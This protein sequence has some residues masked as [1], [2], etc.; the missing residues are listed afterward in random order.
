MNNGQRN[1]SR[2][3]FR[4]GFTGW[5]RGLF[6]QQVISHPGTVTGAWIAPT[7]SGSW[8]TA[9][10]DGSLIAATVRTAVKPLNQE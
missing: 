6:T 1:S 3:F 2:P 8:M 9:S 5:Y 4:A 7:V 10:V